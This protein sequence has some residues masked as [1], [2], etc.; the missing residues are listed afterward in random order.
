VNRVV[1]VHTAFPGDIVL[2]LPL[3][4]RL[5][6]AFP[7]VHIS[8]VTIPPVSDLL[9]NHPA[10]QERIV[11]DKKGSDRGI[12]GMLRCAHVLRSRRFDVALIPHRSLRSALICRMAGMPRRIG[13]STSAGRWLLT[14]RVGDDRAVHEIQRNLALLGPLGVPRGEMLLPSL[15]PDEADRQAVDLFLA[16]HPALDRG[17]LVAVA[18]GSVWNTKRWPAANFADVIR[19]IEQEGLSAVL[20]G[21]E[22]DRDLCAGILA[23]AGAVR[24]VSAAGAFPLLRSAEI[25]RRCRVCVSND[26]AP[27]HLAVA[28]G[29]PVIALFGAT[30]PS[31]GFG[32]AGAEDVVLQTAGLDCRPCSIHGGAVCPIGTFECM[33]RMAPGQVLTEIL[34]HVS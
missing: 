21:G 8:M 27:M 6:A 2:A 5:K 15:Y 31:F 22:A 28:M 32:P 11:Y 14:D 7:H 18:P 23:A 26:S 17:R 1:I 16:A 9:R 30:A 3:A 34:R 10:I 33:H 4:Q 20:I 13:F 12:P 29:T 19:R 24:T 25:I